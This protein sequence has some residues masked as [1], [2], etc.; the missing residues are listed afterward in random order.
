MNLPLNAEIAGKVLKTVDAGLVFGMGE[1]IPGLMCVEAA[2]R[3]AYGLPHSD[4][5]P[6]VGRK[7]RG[8]KII[9][10][11]SYWSTDEAR[12][13][14]LR[15]LAIAQLGSDSINQKEFVEIIEDQIIRRI[16]PLALRHAAERYKGHSVALW[17]AA[18]RCEE[19]G[20]AALKGAKALAK[21]IGATNIKYAIE[22]TRKGVNCGSADYVSDDPD[23]I[24]EALMVVANIGL[25]AL[26]KLKSPGCQYLY[27][28]N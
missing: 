3:F 25:E 4:A 24:D 2:V 14:G 19:E 5:P 22:M 28:C 8:F 17:E 27:L 10:N 18:V 26:K 9:L 7:V 6:C 15:K 12:T 11:D 21:K 20:S 16:I 13:K 23:K 1:P